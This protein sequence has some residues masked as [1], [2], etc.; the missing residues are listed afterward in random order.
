MSS[1]IVVVTSRASAVDKQERAQV[2]ADN[3]SL[4]TIRCRRFGRQLPLRHR[5]R[6]ENTWR[7]GETE[8]SGSSGV[9]FRGEIVAV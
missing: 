3:S 8:N 4:Q 9:L 6:G 2:C 7:R 5:V 1:Q